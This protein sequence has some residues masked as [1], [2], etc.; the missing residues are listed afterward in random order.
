LTS[1]SSSSSLMSQSPSRTHFRAVRSISEASI[2]PSGPSSD[3]IT[4]SPEDTAD[5]LLIAAAPARSRYGT[6]AAPTAGSSGS[7]STCTPPT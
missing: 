3:L 5:V 6:V 4:R 2:Q 7:C 1:L